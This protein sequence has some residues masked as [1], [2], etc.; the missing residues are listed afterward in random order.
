MT[1]GAYWVEM[2]LSVYFTLMSDL[3]LL[4]YFIAAKFMSVEHKEYIVDLGWDN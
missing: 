2:N 4:S 1:A 3:G